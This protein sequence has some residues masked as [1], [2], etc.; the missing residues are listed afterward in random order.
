MSWNGRC[1][2]I[3]LG[4]LGLFLAV[5]ASRGQSVNSSLQGVVR[6]TSGA[7]VPQA[8]VNLT[9]TG[10]GTRLTT[11]TDNVGLYSFPS[12]P[13]GVYSLE[14]TKP[15]F[16]RYQLSQ[17]TL[18][19]GEHATAN[20]TLNVSA[21]T[22]TV[23][24]TAAG[25]ADLLQPESNDLGNVIAPQSVAQ[26]PLNGRNFL[27]LGLLSGATQNNVGAA[28][29]SVNQTGH[30]ALSINIAGNEP[31][32][33]MYLIN[34]I[35]TFG[36]RAGNA[37]LNLS[38]GAI[39]QFEVHYG[40]FM[41]DLGWNPGVVDVITKSGTNSFHGEAYEYMR[42]NNMEARN[43]FSSTPP[44]PYHQ[45]QFGFDLGGP[46]LR[47]KLFFFTNYEGYRQIQSAFVGAYTPTAAMFNGDFSSV[48]S[49]IY[50]PYSFNKTTGQRQ[51]FA[52]NVIPSTFINP[53]S[54]N[55]LHYYLPGSSVSQR[56]INVGGI[57]RTT[58]NSDQFTGRLDAN[59]HESNQLF[60]EG[61]WLNSPALQPGLFPLQGTA[62]PLD[63]ELVALGWTKTISP[64]K[65]NELRLGWTRDSVYDQGISSPG[66]EAKL[67]I[68]GTGDINGVPAINISGYSGFGTGTGLLGDVDDVY[69]IHDSF[70]WLKGN[71]QIKIGGDL[72]YTRAVESSA[73]L[74][75]RG[76]ISFTNLYSSQIKAGANGTY[77][78]VPGTGNAFADFLLGMPTNGEAKAMPL[79]HYRWTSVQPYIEDTWKIR[80]NLTANLALAWFGNTPPNP[81]GADKNLVHGFDFKTGEEIFAALGQMSPEV[82]SM[83]K[84][85]FAP[86]IG[87]SWQPI[88]DTVVR[89]GWGLYYTTQMALNQQYSIVSQ[90]ITVNNSIANSEP[91]PTYLLG[92]N[93]FPPVTVGQITQ[94]QVATISGPIQ[95]LSMTQRSPYIEQWDFDVEHTFAKAYL[96]DVAY[97]GNQ[98]HHLALNYNPIDCSA[99]GTLLCSNA[100]NPYYP[101][102]PYMQEVDS[103]GNSNYNALLVKFQRQFSRGLSILA[104]YTW[105][106]TLSNG[107]EGSNSTLDQ[108]K[109][110]LRCDRGMTTFDVPQALVVST[111]WDLPLGRGRQFVTNMNR[112]L[113][114]IVG[115]WNIDF[116]ATFQ[117]GT[118]FTVTAPNFTVWP[119]DQ[120]RANRVCNGRNELQN[121]DLR[122]N[123]LF[124]INTSCFVQP[125][126]N[127][128][129]NSGFDILN[130]PGLNNWDIGVHKNFAIREAARLDL[131]GEFFN[132]WN[133]AQFA[134][135]NS[136][137]ASSAFGQVSSTQR[138][139]R[140]VQVGL[141]L[142]F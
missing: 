109:S 125:P 72:N 47:N 37:S 106:K 141:R 41:P 116:I 40:F 26:L 101:R 128:F 138:D 9:N 87:L 108:M 56:P 12:L 92:V 46:I 50:N 122:T 105:S 44:G 93:T 121:K 132:A 94:A 30:P 54:Q 77:S 61:N 39:D 126:T 23:T 127:Y 42:N 53:V 22:Q 91:N 45:N 19:V 27:Q 18:V 4:V 100:N 114:A 71:H 124:W 79:T 32:F 35:Q 89:A 49:I 117:Q 111:V 113:D 136:N 98:A 110:C 60:L 57:P 43:F 36:S 102:Y 137:V 20:V 112:Y 140:E 96:I 83:T 74:T 58:L 73:N 78:L 16:A 82:F 118:P 131:R 21:A 8:T 62:Y 66:L 6:D 29:S 59:V 1:K 142:S 107:Q 115:G 24:V 135:P 10:T 139:A 17:F 3:P 75:A 88:H 65:V 52:N 81:S 48:S 86:R 38:V 129:G 64:T 55:L 15:G 68:T 2:M 69:Q 103:I 90:I 67:G 14:V 84:T 97:I 11:E 63:T 120:V 25:L 51:P 104:N 134:N 70:S 34:G 7:S 33:T 123:G 99:P 133:H 85:N 119:A 28:S 31:D 76:S 130:G 5:S 13:P 80:S 95:Y